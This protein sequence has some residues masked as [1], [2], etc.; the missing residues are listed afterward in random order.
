MSKL[1]KTRW[2]WTR[3]RSKLRSRW[4]RFESARKT[5]RRSSAILTYEGWSEKTKTIL[6]R[7]LRKRSNT[8]NGGKRLASRT[9]SESQMTCS[10]LNAK[11]KCVPPS[12]HT[13]VWTQVEFQIWLRICLIWRR[14]PILTWLCKNPSHVSAAKIHPRINLGAV[15]TRMMRMGTEEPACTPHPL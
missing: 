10:C 11:L 2:R 6:L 15:W 9:W 8:R 1:L 7:N 13:R 3:W 5:T 4:P 12:N 14:S